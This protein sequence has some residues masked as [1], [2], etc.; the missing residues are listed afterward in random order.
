MVV[1]CPCRESLFIV[2]SHSQSPLRS[3]DLLS[4]ICHCCR[5][6][7]VGRDCC[8]QPFYGFRIKNVWESGR[9]VQMP[10]DLMWRIHHFGE[11]PTNK[12]SYSLTWKPALLSHAHFYLVLDSNPVLDASGRHFAELQTDNTT[13]S[14]IYASVQMFRWFTLLRCKQYCRLEISHSPLLPWDSVVVSDTAFMRA[15]VHSRGHPSR[16]HAGIHAK[17]KRREQSGKEVTYHRFEVNISNAII[18]VPLNRSTYCNH[19]QTL[20]P[21]AT[22]LN[23]SSCWTKCGI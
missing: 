14:A 9:R 10:H 13:R 18:L 23:H 1:T 19:F 21:V 22:N 8:R 16:L 11:S 6:E 3:S 20:L 4:A 7:A 2:F 17:R 12:S 15:V 5:I